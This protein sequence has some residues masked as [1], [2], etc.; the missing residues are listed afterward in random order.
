MSKDIL[1]AFMYTCKLVHVVPLCVSKCFCP[2]MICFAPACLLCIF[3]LHVFC[4]A[5]VLCVHTNL[6]RIS[7]CYIL[8]YTYNTRQDSVCFLRK[9]APR[10][11]YTRVWMYT[12][13]VANRRR[14]PCFFEG[15]LCPAITSTCAAGN[16]F[17][18]KPLH[19]EAVTHRSLYTDK[20]YTKYLW[21]K[22]L[23]DT[24]TF[25]KAFANRNHHTHRNLYTQKLLH[26]ETFTQTRKNLH[27][28]A[29]YTETFAQRNCYTKNLCRK[30]CLDK[31]TFTDESVCKQK[32]LRAQKPLHA[33]TV[34]H[35]SPQ[36]AICYTKKRLQ[37]EIFRIL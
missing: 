29:V 32:P 33:E 3:A 27:T 1:S 20:C 34:I 37:K 18:R 21:G 7:V 5:S 9:N 2:C 35:R 19:T 13:D 25:A 24:G 30:N 31:G 17:T 22:K 28:E 8:V 36:K 14:I 26:I 10:L 12:C 15:K 11:H 23:L 16:K 6:T 4:S